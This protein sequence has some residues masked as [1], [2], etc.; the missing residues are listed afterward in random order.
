MHVNFG[1]FLDIAEVSSDAPT[2]KYHF[3]VYHGLFDWKMVLVLVS[4]VPNVPNIPFLQPGYC[5]V[6]VT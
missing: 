3:Y 2:Q 5:V 4:G 1:V 6:C